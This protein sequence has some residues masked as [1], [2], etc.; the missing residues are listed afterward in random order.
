MGCVLL[1]IVSNAR[2]LQANAVETLYCE[3][4]RRRK[5]VEDELSKIKDELESTRNQ[6]NMALD[7][8]RVAVD[9]KLLLTNR[10]DRSNV[11]WEELDEKLLSAL[12]LLHRMKNIS[13]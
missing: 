12:E 5:E 10:A 3:E 2:I 11:I 7:E 9:Q 8:P 4:L 1:K 13:C 6:H